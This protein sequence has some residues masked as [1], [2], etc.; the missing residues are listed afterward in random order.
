VLI[1]DNHHPIRLAMSDKYGFIFFSYMENTPY[2]LILS[3]M[4]ST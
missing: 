1:H 4:G 2:K 3:I